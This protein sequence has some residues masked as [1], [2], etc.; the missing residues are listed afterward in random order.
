M[1]GVKKTMIVDASIVVKWFVPERDYEIALK[2]RDAH[3]KGEVAIQAPSLL[4]Y[5]VINALRFHKVYKLSYEVLVR[6]SD[7]LKATG[8]LEEPSREAWEYGIKTS[9]EK[10]ISLYDSIY[11]GMA[12]AANATLITSDKV[13]HNK[14]KDI[15]DTILLRNL[16]FT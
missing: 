7:A 10:G 9:L 8:I 6:V 16:K 2:I 14:V 4:L 12:K 13:L 1:E 15:V 3:I 5:E 11:V